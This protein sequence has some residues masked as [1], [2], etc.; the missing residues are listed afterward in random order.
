MNDGALL[1]GQSGERIGQFSAEDVF[2]GV[3]RPCEG[4]RYFNGKIFLRSFSRAAPAHQINRCITREPDEKRAFI[5]DPIQQLR[6]ASEFDE[7]FLKQVARVSVIAREVQ[8]KGIKRLRVPVVEP[9]DFGSAPHF[10]NDARGG[11][12]CLAK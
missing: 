5:T 8:E 9:F 11:G 7:N 2:V 6:L 10:L 3:A 4:G 12:I 1:F